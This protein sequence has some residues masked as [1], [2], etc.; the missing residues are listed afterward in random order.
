MANGVLTV[1]INMFVVQLAY[2][3]TV[4]VCYMQVELI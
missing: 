4:N 1:T 2:T 3:P